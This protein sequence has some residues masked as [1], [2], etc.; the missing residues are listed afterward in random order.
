MKNILICDDEKD[1]V[2]ALKIYL[3]NGDYNIYT[4]YNGK[5]AVDLVRQNDAQNGRNNRNVHHTKF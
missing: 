4:A 5:E 3:N 1:I 2:D